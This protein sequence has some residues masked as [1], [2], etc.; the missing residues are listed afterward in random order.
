MNLKNV[1]TIVIT[2]A[3]VAAV[4]I[5]IVHKYEGRTIDAEAAEFTLPAMPI[6]DFNTAMEENLGKNAV[7]WTDVNGDLT[8][9]KVDGTVDITELSG[10]KLGSFIVK[11]TDAG[12]FNKKFIS[13]YENAAD[14]L[15]QK[16]VANELAIGYWEPIVV[17]VT[18]KLKE[19]P[20]VT[21]EEISIYADGINKLLELG[22]IMQTLF[23]YQIGAEQGDRIKAETGDDR[24]L[25]DRYG[26]PWCVMDKSPFCVALPD[27]RPQSSGVLPM[28]VPCDVS[29]KIGSP[30]EVVEK[31]PEGNLISQPYN[32]IWTKELKEASTV[33]NE[34]SEILSKIPREEKFAKYLR[35]QAAAF[36]SLTPFPYADSD[37]SWID[38]LKSD[39]L[40]FTRIGPDEVGYGKVGDKC[41]SR[42]R[43]SFNLGLKNR[44]AAKA[45]EDLKPLIQP[46]ENAYAKILDDTSIYKPRDVIIELPEF[47][48]TMA[49]KGDSQSNPALLMVAQTLPNWCGADGKGEC[50]HGT[51]VYI[52]KS[53]AAYSK[54]ML[55]TYFKPLLNSAVYEK[56]GEGASAYKSA[57]HELFH[58]MGPRYDQVKLGTDAARSS[59]LVSAKGK[60][61]STIMEETKAETGAVFI[62]TYLYRDVLQKFND[63]LIPKEHLEKAAADYQKFLASKFLWTQGQ[64]LKTTIN[65][66]G[67]SSPYGYAAAVEVGFLAEKGVLNYDENTKTWS[68]DFDKAPAAIDDLVKKIG[69]LYAKADPTA[70]ESFYLYY[71]S[72]DGEKLLHRDRLFE[73]AGKRP[74]MIP[75]YKI[76]GL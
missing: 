22:P 20:E 66:A 27:I 32:K 68:I 18:A 2:V 44:E 28:D 37:Q 60:P 46:I 3:I 70:V 67:F 36:G 13:L 21:D 4:A 40:L 45:V 23:Q 30:F 52:N 47:I 42:A 58:N 56:L 53:N 26:F 51:M 74:Y 62:A 41:D 33:L 43:F 31:N 15:R 50:R 54:K 8:F 17:D 25:I 48:D 19:Y 61:W 5:L 73:V 69:T 64:I 49:E 1:I 76:K 59:L 63:G 7:V 65:N 39:S 16:H 24:E 11:G 75:E 14:L 12:H 57:L 71:T 34:A 72:G 38:A 10:K 29:N 35:D 6:A 55:D 9:I